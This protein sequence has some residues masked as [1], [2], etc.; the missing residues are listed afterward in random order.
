MKNIGVI[1]ENV[2]L[3]NVSNQTKEVMKNDF[4]MHQLEINNLEGYNVWLPF[5]FHL[6]HEALT[7]RPEKEE[8]SSD[9]I[10]DLANHEF[11]WLANYFEY[12]GIE[13]VKRILQNRGFCFNKIQ[14][15]LQESNLNYTN[16][17]IYQM[18]NN[19][20]SWIQN[21]QEKEKVSSIIDEVRKSW[22]QEYIK[23]RD[24]KTSKENPCELLIVCENK[25]NA[26]TNLFEYIT[27]G[28][29]LHFMEMNPNKTLKEM[30]L[31][32]KEEDQLKKLK[33][34]ET[35]I[36]TI[37]SVTALKNCKKIL[38]KTVSENF[39]NY[40]Q[41]SNTYTQNKLPFPTAYNPGI[42]PGFVN[43]KTEKQFIYERK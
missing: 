11:S 30:M 28:K 31:E 10:S 2:H 29:Q 42:Y 19:D 26:I 36:D 16:Q 43:V 7:Y 35:L 3:S 9:D 17:Q 22:Y 15:Y 40:P 33:Q 21:E 41:Y 8:L 25:E 34:I 27:T 24:S 6:Y 23:D 32:K 18:E 5:D 4:F 20:I 39:Q 14:K 38:I 1:Y 13:N 37:Q 12:D